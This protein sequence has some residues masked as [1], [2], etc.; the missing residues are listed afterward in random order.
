MTALSSTRSA[1]LHHAADQPP[2]MP[3]V[4]H[5]EVH[6]SD[7]TRMIPFYEGMF[8]WRFEAYTGGWE[9]WV[10]RTGDAGAP[11]I[12]GGLLRRRGPAPVEGQPVNA[13]VC[14]VDV[15]S[16]EDALARSA[17]LGGSLAVPRMAV[18]GV[19]W[20]AYVKDPDGNILGLLQSDPT[21][22]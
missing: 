13:F 18:P 5:F 16:V 10:I 4:V 6:A 2:I 21:A 14:T 19:G 17:S 22:A 7:P 15:S 11:G 1:S 20:L 3:R 9:Y 8:G 12:D